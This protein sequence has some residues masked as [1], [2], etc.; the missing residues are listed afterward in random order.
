V[1]RVGSALLLPPLQV[2][3]GRSIQRSPQYSPEV[4]RERQGRFGGVGVSWAQFQPKRG[5]N[6]PAIYLGKMELRACGLHSL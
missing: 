2:Q 1:S 5:D 6:Q 3:V 4:P